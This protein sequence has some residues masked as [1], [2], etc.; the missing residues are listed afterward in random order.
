MRQ[1]TPPSC[2]CLLLIAS[3]QL[4]ACQPPPIMLRIRPT[5]LMALGVPGTFHPLSLSSHSPCPSSSHWPS[6]ICSWDT[7]T[8]FGASA[9]AIPSAWKARPPP[10]MAC[11]LSH[12]SSQQ[13]SVASSPDLQPQACY[14]IFL[15]DFSCDT[16]PRLSSLSLMG[17]LPK[18]GTWLFTA[19]YPAPALC[20]EYL[21]CSMSLFPREGTLTLLRP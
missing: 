16:C 13:M 7:P 11:S 6:S 17:C 2:Y 1:V 8:H 9:P 20:L 15:L 12:F 21:L 3:L 4:T 5:C 18:A 19:V 10:R 14:P